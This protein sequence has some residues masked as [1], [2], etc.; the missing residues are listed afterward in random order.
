L[1]AT[2]RGGTREANDFY[3]TPT[4]LTEA[5]IPHLGK[6]RHILEPAAG[7]G[8]IV[9]VLHRAFS[10]A[11]IDHGDITTGQDFLTYAWR[12]DY[13]DL[14]ITNPPYSLAE[15]F[16][17]RA[18]SL[19]K[20]AGTVVMLSRVSFA[21]SQGRAAWLR[22]TQPS[23]YFSPRR[24]CF[25]RGKSDNCEY[26]WFVWSPAAP[27]CVWLETEAPSSGDLFEAAQ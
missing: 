19:V 6:P 3:P 7:D 2:N 18:L 11:E 21:G 25:V 1:S 20:P 24:P 5:L 22:A 15:E 14:I 16:A 4:W 10:E 27:T 8:A 12:Q 23:L 26:A 13:Y 17:R 9:G